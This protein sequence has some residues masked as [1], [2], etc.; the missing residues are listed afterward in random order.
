MSSEAPRSP[1]DATVDPLL[2]KL[3]QEIVEK[4]EEE[5]NKNQNEKKHSTSPTNPT[6]PA[7][8]TSPMSPTSPLERTKLPENHPESLPQ[9]NPTTIHD[10]SV[11]QQKIIEDCLEI[12]EDQSHDK[13]E[14]K[15]AQE[16]EEKATNSPHQQTLE[17][18]QQI[19]APPN[20]VYTDPEELK[21]TIKE[22]AVANGYAIVMR[23]SVPGKSMIFKCDR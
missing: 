21:T 7:S 13:N 22:F 17:E 6:S 23:R 11:H 9:I 3:T 12:L 14:E 20:G 8:P 15:S 4:R 1:T 2:L 18:H 19:P 16:S 10:H 5:A